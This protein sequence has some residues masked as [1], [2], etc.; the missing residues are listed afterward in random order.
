MDIFTENS[1]AFPSEV[2]AVISLFMPFNC[3]NNTN[4]MSRLYNDRRNEDQNFDGEFRLWFVKDSFITKE[5][6]KEGL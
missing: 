3:L 1:S 4:L 5:K 6:L 2:N